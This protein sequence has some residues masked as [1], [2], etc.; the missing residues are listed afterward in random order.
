M[1]RAA[2]M[3]LLC[4]GLIAVVSA[5]EGPKA[6][7]TDPRFHFEATL[8]GSAVEH[9]FVLKNLSS[10][11]L[12]IQKV[13]MTPPLIV[14]TMPHEV[15]GGSEGKIHFEL[16]TSHLSGAFQGEILV[17]L[18]DPVQPEIELAFEGRIVPLI[19]VVPMPAFYV[20]AGRGES[21]RASV[22]IVNHEAEL[23][24]IQKVEHS[25]E[26]FTTDLETIEPGRRYRLTL[27][28][29][30]DGPDG[31]TAETILVRNSSKN[32]PML[33][34][35]ANTYLHG[36]V[37]TFPETVD[38][39]AF[40]LR[41]IQRAPQILEVAR[42]TLMIYQEGGTDFQLHV[43]TDVPGLELKSERGPKGDRFQVTVTLT[44]SLLQ[45]G[46][47]RGSVFIETN[48]HEFRKLAVPVSGEIL[49]K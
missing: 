48:D 8:S 3:V 29:K 22:E 27:I 32:M 44:P 10:S 49:L 36:R 17:F 4:I 9:D 15:L 39:G 19:E 38:L 33:P 13:S 1:I 46:L 5:S 41:D 30:P 42:Q 2:G 40:R 21:K 16:D 18:D 37:Y 34:I 35:Q 12:R 26:R 11:P 45:V 7:V 43:T 6:T 24:S 25:T 14:T 31:K 23:L 20:A 47:L 28:L